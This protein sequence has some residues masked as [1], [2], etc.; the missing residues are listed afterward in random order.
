MPTYVSA[1]AAAAR[2]GVSDRTI[3]RWIAS[4]RLP[5]DKAEGEFR[6]ALEDLDGLTGHGAAAAAAPGHE[7]DTAAAPAGEDSPP[8]AAPAA[9]LSAQLVALVALVERQQAQLLE[10]TEA[11]AMWQARARVLDERVRMLE[12]PKPEPAPDPFPQP[13]PPAPNAAPWDVRWQTRAAVAVGVLATLAVAA[14]WV[15]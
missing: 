5:A 6:I 10:R 8:G 11:A 13:T 7:Q 12:A 15:R 2:L 1:H 14:A 4:G 3:R 9:A